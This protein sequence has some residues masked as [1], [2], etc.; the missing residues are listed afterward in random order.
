MTLLI[1]VLRRIADEL[2]HGRIDAEL[3]TRLDYLTEAMAKHQQRTGERAFQ[4]TVD[5]V[6]DSVDAFAPEGDPVRTPSLVQTALAIGIVVG[7][8]YSS[9]EAS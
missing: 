3:P 5:A 7:W 1:S 8:A 2:L 6:I 9:R 4:H